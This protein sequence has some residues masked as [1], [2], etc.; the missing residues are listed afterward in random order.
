MLPSV[1]Y[2]FSVHAGSPESAGQ[3]G[4]AGVLALA[5]KLEEVGHGRASVVVKPNLI[6]DRHPRD[7]NGWAYTL[8]HPSILKEVLWQFDRLLPG[9]ARITLTDAPQGDAS[10]KNICRLLG[11]TELVAD[12]GAAGREVQLLDLRKQESVNDEG[13]IVERRDLP[14]DP[15]GYVAVDLGEYSEFHGH[16]GAGRYYGADYDDNEVNYHHSDGRHEYLVS[17]TVLEADLFVNLPKLKTHK[18]V[19]VTAALKNLVGING[20]K[21]WLPHHTEPSLANDGDERPVAGLLSRVERTAVRNL[22]HLSLKYPRSGIALLGGMRQIGQK[23]LGD[24]ESVVRSGNWWGNDT[25]WRMCLDLNKV[26]LYANPDGSL[27]KPAPESQKPYL[28]LV[29]G[30]L[31]GQGNGPINPDPIQSNIVLFGSNPASVDAAC[32]VFMGF[33]PDKIPLIR[34]AFRCKHYP[35]ASWDWREVRVVSNRDEWNGYLHQ[36]PPGS[37]PRFRPH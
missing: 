28:A 23:A 13:V 20:D 29:D 37:T 8:T 30:I 33:D 35:I 7:A 12:A 32:A 6:H 34:Q 31:G 15:L 16:A 10:F 25:T 19:G 36:I 14:G 3:A 18:K 2:V 21:N 17:R 27:R 11:L 5:G 4:V 1:V 26:L 24:G 9:G 22:R